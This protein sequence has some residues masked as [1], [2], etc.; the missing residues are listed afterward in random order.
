MSYVD[1]GDD[2]S[3]HIMYGHK[4]T[5]NNGGSDVAH[6]ITGINKISVCSA[7]EISGGRT[8]RNRAIGGG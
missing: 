7:S 6:I 1:D 2:Y 4:M 3:L 5:Y 8:I